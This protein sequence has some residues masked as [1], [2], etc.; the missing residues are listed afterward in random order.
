MFLTLSFLAAF[1]GGDWS[2]RCAQLPVTRRRAKFGVRM[3]IGASPADV[4]AKVIAKARH[5]RRRL[6]TVSAL[7]CRFWLGV[8]RADL[9]LPPFD[10]ATLAG[11]TGWR[12]VARRLDHSSATRVHGG[13]MA[14]LRDSWRL[15]CRLSAPLISP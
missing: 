5:H 2:L 6:A 8:E 14:A 12:R 9:S 13:P 4:L 15:G 1:R 10:P 7:V 3:A 11:E